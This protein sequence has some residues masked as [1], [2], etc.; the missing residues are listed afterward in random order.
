VRKGVCIS[1][2][3]AAVGGCEQKNEK[4]VCGGTGYVIGVGVELVGV[5]TCQMEGPIC[6]A[7]EV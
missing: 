3:V 7:V 2:E 4:G 5:S 6:K 1:A